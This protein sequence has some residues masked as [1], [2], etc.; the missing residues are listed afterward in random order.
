MVDSGKIATDV[1]YLSPD[2]ED[3]SYIAQANEPTSK[4]KFKNKDIRVRN[5]DDFPVIDSAKVNYVDVSPSQIV[6]ISASLIPFLENDDANR[7]LMGSNMMRQSVPLMNP[8][9]PIV[10]TG[11]EEVVAKDSRAAIYSEDSGSVKY[12]DA[13]KII[14]ET[15]GE[16]EELELMKKEKYKEYSLRKF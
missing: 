16:P 12:A 1:C 2:E 11:M 9:P 15:S 3:R 14:I 7:A 8:E 4:N 6:S 13:D 10:A 5:G